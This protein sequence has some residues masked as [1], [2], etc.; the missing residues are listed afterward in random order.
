MA[1]AENTFFRRVLGIADQVF[2]GEEIK[3]VFAY[4]FL[5]KGY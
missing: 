5:G 1:Q 4:C 2:Q 3:D